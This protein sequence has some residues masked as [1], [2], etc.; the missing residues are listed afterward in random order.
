MT[1]APTRRKHLKSRNGCIQCKKRKIKCDENG[2]VPCAQCVKS[3]HACSFAP[4][5]VVDSNFSTTS[6]LDLELLHNYTTKTAWS[7]SE[8][9]EIQRFFGAEFV[10]LAMQNDY[11]LHCILGLSAFHMANQ[12]GK[13]EESQL[14]GLGHSKDIY[15][16]AAYSHHDSALKGYRQCISTLNQ[17]T[18]H[19]SFGCACLLFITSFARPTESDNRPNQANNPAHV[20]LGY[21]LSEWIILIK[22]LPSILTYDEFRSA[23]ENGPVAPLMKDTDDHSA[24]DGTPPMESEVVY[25]RV[26]DLST[27]IGENSSD[28]RIVQ[29]CQSSIETLCSIVAELKQSSDHV[30]AFIWPIRVDPEYLI[31]L[32]ERKPEALLVFAYYCALLYMSS[33]RWWTKGWPPP[34]VESIRDTIDERWVPWLQWPLQVIFAGTGEPFEIAER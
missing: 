18:C 34:I 14:I 11:L 29:I 10:Q 22:G 3:R 28:E 8:N 19:A 15:L 6:R 20:W 1:S 7:L 25:H 5:P 32:E 24:Q 2:S 27:A 17:A 31:I 9:V 33:S 30:L 4:P 21:R 13:I 26:R 16:R 23:L 12:H